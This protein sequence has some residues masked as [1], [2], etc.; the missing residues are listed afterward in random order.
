M[1]TIEIDYTPDLDV[2]DTI[3]R[4]V[5]M[6]ADLILAG[7][8]ANDLYVIQKHAKEVG[9]R[10]WCDMGVSMCEQ[11]VRVKILGYSTDVEP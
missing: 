10:K 6:G 11:G 1:S 8:T 7:A 9:R 5:W 3:A 4:Y 2:Q